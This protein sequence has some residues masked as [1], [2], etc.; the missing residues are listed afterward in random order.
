[1]YLTVP[2]EIKWKH[3]CLECYSMM[4]IE[5]EDVTTFG[6]VS[7]RVLVRGCLEPIVRTALR[8]R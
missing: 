4:D 3:L 2:E 6:K 8:N 1:M 7:M 5:F